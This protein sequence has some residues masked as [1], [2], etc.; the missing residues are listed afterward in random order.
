MVSKHI[1]LKGP[2]HSAPGMNSLLRGSCPTENSKWLLVRKFH[3]QGPAELQVSRNMF[4]ENSRMQRFFSVPS[5]FCSV[6]V[7]VLVFVCL[8]PYLVLFS[9]IGGGTAGMRGDVAD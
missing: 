1:S 8:L 5:V 6:L 3:P 9:F 2:L 7:F 4:F